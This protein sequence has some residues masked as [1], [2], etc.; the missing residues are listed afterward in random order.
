MEF[1]Q[2]PSPSAVSMG[3]GAFG[4]AAALTPAWF[5]PLVWT[6]RPQRRF[7][8]VPVEMGPFSP[9]APFV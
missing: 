4:L 6:L 5:Q 7:A 2:S 3:L 1:W 8:H 9:L